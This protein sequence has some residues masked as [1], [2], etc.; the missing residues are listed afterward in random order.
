MRRSQLV[1]VAVLTA[2]LLSPSSAAWAGPGGDP[3]CALHPNDSYCADKNYQV[4]RG[5]W[6]WKIARKNLVAHGFGT[7]DLR[8]VRSHANAIYAKNRAVIGSNPSRIRPG[9]RLVLPSPAAI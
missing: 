7:K 2:G 3:I 6:L 5:D 8:V 4:Q 9:M 1:V